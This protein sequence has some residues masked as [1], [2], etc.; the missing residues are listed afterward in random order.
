[1]APRTLLAPPRPPA[2]RC[3]T[4]SSSAVALHL[5]GPVVLA[6]RPAP[7]REHGARCG[8]QVCTLTLPRRGNSDET[9]FPQRTALVGTVPAPHAQ[10]GFSLVLLLPRRAGPRASVYLLWVTCYWRAGQASGGF[11]LPAVCWAG[12]PHPRAEVHRRVLAS[13]AW[14]PAGTPRTPCPRSACL[15]ASPCLQG[16]GVAGLG[17]GRTRS[18]SQ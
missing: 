4:S 12:C 17:A 11:S 18:S 14:D 7:D 1:M 5:L 8:V 15:G 10:W 9:Q 6:L 3:V 16:C 2:P 13:L